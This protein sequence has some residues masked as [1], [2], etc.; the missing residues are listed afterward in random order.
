[1]KIA[2]W[3][4]PRNLST[5][6][7]YAFGNRADFAAWDEPFYAAYLAR[8]GADHPV[9]D[10]VVARHETDPAKIAAACAGPVPGGKVHWYMKHMPHHMLPGFPLD[11]AEPCVNIHLIRHPARVVAS[12]LAK[13]ESPTLD[14]LGF[15]Q[16]AELFARLPGPV[17]DSDDIRRDPEGMLH[18]LCAR[19]G[20]DFD[21]AMLAWP[22]GPKGFDGAWAGHWYGAVHA[23]TGF[24][25]PEGPLPQLTGDA[26][27]LADAALPFYEDLKNRR[28]L[29]D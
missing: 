13:R 18:K 26:A 25:P 16:Q 29:P 7:M 17:I 10:L 24:A 23:S 2:M 9:G 11:W 15:R 1:M 12:Y 8:S 14:D 21:P 3:S 28:I 20:L 6:M 4:G 22:S 19:I 27:R 5:A